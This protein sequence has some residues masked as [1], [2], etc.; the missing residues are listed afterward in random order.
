MSCFSYAGVCIF[1]RI[2]VAFFYKAFRAFHTACAWRMS[3]MLLGMRHLCVLLP[4]GMRFGKTRFIMV[5]LIVC[6]RL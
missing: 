4:F 5:E 3:S 6:D 2:F 1:L